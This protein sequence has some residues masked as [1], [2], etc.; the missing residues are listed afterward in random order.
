MLQRSEKTGAAM[1]KSDP[2]SPSG[3]W[4]IHQRHFPDINK[5]RPPHQN[6]AKVQKSA[7]NNKKVSKRFAKLFWLV[8]GKNK[9]TCLPS[10]PNVLLIV[11]MLANNPHLIF[12]KC[13][14][15]SEDMR[16]AL[17]NS[18]GS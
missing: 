8:E 10:L 4:M 12:G 14:D 5:L 11:V 1:H 7:K 17:D 16:S 15:H 9:E 3:Q 2:V 13:V 6:E 18:D